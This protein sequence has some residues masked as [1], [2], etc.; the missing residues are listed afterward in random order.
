MINSYNPRIPKWTINEKDEK[1]LKIR[2][3]DKEEDIDYIIIMKVN[4]CKGMIDISQYRLIT[5]YPLVMK[6]YK[7]RFDREYKRCIEKIKK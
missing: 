7:I 4:Y 3:I 1:H 2:F 5:A 6:S